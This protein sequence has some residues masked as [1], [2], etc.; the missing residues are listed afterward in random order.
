MRHSFPTRR[1]SDLRILP[2]RAARSFVCPQ[3]PSVQVAAPKR[4]TQPNHITAQ[5]LTRKIDRLGLFWV[6]WPSGAPGCYALLRWPWSASLAGRPGRVSCAFQPLIRV[7]CLID[8]ASL[9]QHAHHDR[10]RQRCLLASEQIFDLPIS[11]SPSP[12]CLVR[13]GC[14][15]I[16]CVP[17]WPATWP[18][19]F[20]MLAGHAPARIAWH[21]D[22]LQ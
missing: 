7:K 16:P 9:V 19:F 1:S 2:P 21:H 13:S 10:Q 14:L 17:R 5:F 8:A 15:S 20:R 11:G 22:L 12:G 3:F 6:R 4:S 18:T